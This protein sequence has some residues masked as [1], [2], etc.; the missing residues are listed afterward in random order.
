MPEISTSN[1][2]LIWRSFGMGLVPTLELRFYL[3]W[4]SLQVLFTLIIPIS[5]AALRVSHVS[6]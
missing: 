1:N 5:V 3:F 2:Q 6:K 4:L